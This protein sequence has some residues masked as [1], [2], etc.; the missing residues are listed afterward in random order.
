MSPKSLSHIYYAPCQQWRVD[1]PFQRARSKFAVEKMPAHTGHIAHNLI[2][3]RHI[4]LGFIR[5]GPVKRKDSIKVLS[6]IASQQ[7]PIVT[8][9]IDQ[10]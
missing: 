9:S 5:L 2:I 7:L 3:L 4:S 8:G 10:P 1:Y 6:L